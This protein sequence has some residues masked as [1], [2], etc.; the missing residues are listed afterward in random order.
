MNLISGDDEKKVNSTKLMTLHSRI[1]PLLC[2]FVLEDEEST[3][4][5]NSLKSDTGKE[6][7]I[8]T[9]FVRKTN[10]SSLSENS[11]E[12]LTEDNSDDHTQVDHT[13][14]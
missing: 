14:A 7:Y 8:T 1:R 3:I 12:M 2:C 6:K 11:L 4:K 10:F 13:L 5:K 9:K